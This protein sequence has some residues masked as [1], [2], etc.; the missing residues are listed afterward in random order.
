MRTEE[1]FGLTH[2]Q[3]SNNLIEEIVITKLQ[4]V[5]EEKGVL[6]VVLA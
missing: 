5:L 2:S 4:K 3:S 6:I 1:K